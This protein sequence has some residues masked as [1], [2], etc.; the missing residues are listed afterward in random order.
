MRSESCHA[1]G[2]CRTQKRRT[3]SAPR[4][5]VRAPHAP[6]LNRHRRTTTRRHAP[7]CAQ[8]LLFDYYDLDQPDPD[9]IG[10]RQAVDSTGVVRI[11][12]GGCRWRRRGGCFFVNALQHELNGPATPLAVVLPIALPAARAVIAGVTDVEVLGIRG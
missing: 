3:G 12:R 1:P 10:A 5:R 6:A 9:W 8:Q 11:A 2:R 4:R 7:G